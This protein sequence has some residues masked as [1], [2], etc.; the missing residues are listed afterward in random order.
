MGRAE[1]EGGQEASR[2]SADIMLIFSVYFEQP[3]LDYTAAVH[4]IGL[5]VNPLGILTS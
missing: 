5:D 2:N 3:A 1:S 4:E